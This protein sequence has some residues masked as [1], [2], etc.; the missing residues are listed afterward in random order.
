M[1]DDNMENTLNIY[2]IIVIRSEE[3]LSH[4]HLMSDEHYGTGMK[5]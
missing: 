3:T 5:A 2:Q 4:T 1:N